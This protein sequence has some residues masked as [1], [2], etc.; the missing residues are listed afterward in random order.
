M[1]RKAV[2]L[3]GRIS[4]HKIPRRDHLYFAANDDRK[5][6]PRDLQG[7][8]VHYIGK[9]LITTRNC[10]RDQSCNAFVDNVDLIGS[11]RHRVMIGDAAGCGSAARKAPRQGCAASRRM[12]RSEK[13]ISRVSANERG[14]K[15]TRSM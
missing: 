10:E 7:N 5:I 6:R 3:S 12:P 1:R 13:N 2:P 15:R 8:P 14:K 9:R 11:G 4:S